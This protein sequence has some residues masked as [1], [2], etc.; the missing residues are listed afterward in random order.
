MSEQ[1]IRTIPYRFTINLK[2]KIGA[3]FVE[4]NIHKT[5]TQ[6]I[7]RAQSVLLCKFF[8]KKLHNFFIFNPL[9]LS[10]MRLY[11]YKGVPVT[12]NTVL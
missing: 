8:N 7:L 1:L 2:K 9:Y 10:L 5:N 3:P 12:D 11:I 4:L 6:T